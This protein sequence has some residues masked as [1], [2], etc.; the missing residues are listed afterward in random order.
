VS[1]RI[2]HLVIVSP[3]LDAGAAL[4]RRVLGVEMQTG[5][6]HARMGTHNL[7]L[8]LGESLFLEVIAANPRAPGPGRPRWFALDELAPRTLPR[9]ATWVARTNDIRAVA[10]ASSEPLGN[11]EPMMRGRLSWLITI[12]ADG[13]LPLGGV[14]PALIEWQAEPH[15]AAGLRDAGC[16]LLRLE[17]FHPE[18]ARVSA[19]LRSISLE[20]PIPAV[21]PLPAGGRPS[22]V[23]HIQTPTGVVR[24]GQAS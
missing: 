8:K 14:A 1:S 9:L 2:D 7:L 21:A 18:P 19:L 4:V 13:A 15:P 24:L 20:G 16:S 17:L 6:D 11:I 12:P 10:A 22:L 5:G 3:D 23:A